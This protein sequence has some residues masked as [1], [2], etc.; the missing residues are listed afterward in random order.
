MKSLLITIL[1]LAFLV[2]SFAQKGKVIESIEFKSKIVSYPV[3]YSVYLRLTT[4]PRNA[5]I[6]YFTFCMV[7]LMMKPG[8]FSL[9]RP[10]KLRIKE[11]QK[12]L[13]QPV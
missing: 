13:S 6:R 7:T 3:R 11:F 8:G 12:G 9:E 2:P 4:N 5:A 10:M 1:F